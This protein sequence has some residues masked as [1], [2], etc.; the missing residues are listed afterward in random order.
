MGKYASRNLC[1]ADIETTG[2]DEQQHEIIEIA[3]VIYSP[4]ED[5]II[6]EWEKKIA[7]RHIETASDVA[8]KLNGYINNPGSY[9]GSLRSALIKFNSLVKDAMIIGQNIKFDTRFI[10][11]YMEEF[12]IKPSFGRHQELDLMAM[13]WIPL[14]KS[15]IPG[16]S[17]AHLCDHFNISNVGAHGALIDCRRTFEVYQCLMRMHKS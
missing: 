14:H 13:T 2:L 12:N 1:F 3:A 6:A 11:K 10:R 8:L 4:S 15:D 9:R 5:K 7:P 16:L 17:L